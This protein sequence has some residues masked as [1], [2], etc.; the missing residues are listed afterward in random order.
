MQLEFLV[1][2]I[3]LL[4]L[5]LVF[6]SN[7]LF[8]DC[9]TREPV[10]YPF[11]KFLLNREPSTHSRIQTHAL[12]YEHERV[13][14]RGQFPSIGPTPRLGRRFILMTRRWQDI[15]VHQVV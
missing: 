4:S 7:C 8:N 15:A 5:S 3:P 1:D 6:I 10:L 9:Q 12:I 2:F 13:L 11:I 14:L